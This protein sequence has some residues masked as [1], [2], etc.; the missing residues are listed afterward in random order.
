MNKKKWH[1]KWDGRFGKRAQ[2]RG[3]ATRNPD[4]KAAAV[5]LV[6]EGLEQR[7]EFEALA[8]ADAYH[9]GRRG[10]MELLLEPRNV[11]R[12]RKYLALE[13]AARVLKRMSHGHTTLR[14]AGCLFPP[15][16]GEALSL[17]QAA[18]LCG[19]TRQ[20]GH[21]ALNTYLWTVERRYRLLRGRWP[22]KGQTPK[23]AP[24]KR[25]WMG[26]RG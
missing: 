18:R 17:A 19:L 9:M 14:L 12:F 5:A 15:G 7:R 24:K 22:G 3:R 20:Q 8:R 26:R 6:R 23:P 25:Y 11:T 10:R 13:D 2:K 21:T 16:G 4:S 1:Q